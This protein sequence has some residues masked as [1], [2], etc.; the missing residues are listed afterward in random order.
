MSRI[1]R[2]D[3]VSFARNGEEAR[4]SGNRPRLGDTDPS[5]L[6]FSR[7]QQQIL[8]R[9][10]A[11][12]LAGTGVL[13]LTGDVGTGKTF[14]ARA[15]VHRLRAD[16]IIATPMYTR[17][18]PQDFWREVGVAWG[19]EGAPDTLEAL[20]AGLTGLLDGA[21][22]GNKRV[23]L[24][25]DEAQ[26]LSR[27]LLAEIGRLAVMAGEPRSPARLSILLVGQ[28]GLG[29]V[30]SRSENAELAKRVG[31]R[32]VTE[33]L[34]EA[35]VRE[36]VAHQLSRD[37]RERA[38]FS[39]DGL[40]ELVLASQGIPRQIN[41]I[42]ELALLSSWR[43]GT[44]A[45][46]AGVVRG[47][48]RRLGVERPTPPRA[49]PTTR[50]AL[51]RRAR[52]ALLCIPA[53]ALLTALAMYVYGTAW[54]RD[55]TRAVNRSA[56]PAAA[57][58]P[59]PSRSS[60]PAPPAE[61]PRLSEPGRSAADAPGPPDG[62]V[63][64]PVD[65]PPTARPAAPPASEPGPSAA[66]APGPPVGSVQRPV[67]PPPTARPAA[68]RA[69]EPRSS[70]AAVPGPPVGSVQPAPVPPAPIRPLPRPAAE[71]TTARSGSP[72]DAA[73]A[74]RT[75]VVT[76]PTSSGARRPPEVQA[77]EESD[78]GGIIDWLLSE[79]PARRQ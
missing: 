15:L 32:Y 22:G 9:L 10:R 47:C 38:V 51:P 19:I 54:Q 68:P 44:A 71:G 5:R 49:T 78:P 76:A 35:E 58:V 45:I 1:V 26:S 74:A 30:L 60:G 62:S 31:A 14:L 11:D 4:P 12:V 73:P 46:G 2:P 17:E 40:R 23:L 13:F 77:A 20:Y 70:A 42:V 55:P 75:Q 61:A 39:D 28:Y 69:G 6:W 66:D 65:P 48:V 3:A 34:T 67:D 59:V 8:D 63:Q 7:G 24:F 18:D 21:A 43:E 50:M 16:A 36:Y 33:P 52:W 53:L 37:G 56:R 25:V 57:L 27:D 72:A 29:T 79:Y 41:S 64:R